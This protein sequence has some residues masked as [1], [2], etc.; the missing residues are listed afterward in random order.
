MNIER[1][2]NRNFKDTAFSQEEILEL[3]DAC[4]AIW[5]HDGNPKKP[6]AE[7][8][9]GMC[10]NGFVDCLKVLK[11]PE[12][13]EILAKQL[14]WELKKKGVLIPDW[15]IG[16]PYADITFSYEVAKAFGAKHNFCEKDPVNPKKMIWRRELI[17]AGETVL[18]IEELITTS[19]TF[20]EIRRAVQEGNP[21]PVDFFPIVG[22]LVH[23]PPKLP[24]DYGDIKVVAL[25]EKEIWAVNPEECPL[26]KAGSERLRPKIKENWEKL[27]AKE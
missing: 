19:G 4:G 10:S 26:C 13:C 17:P 20:Q 24:A 27:T 11:Y 1:W 25:I 9:S 14:F 15:V 3:F 6:H 18:Q 2:K 22:A 12:L 7:L 23:R 16:S 5:L 8:T 21:E